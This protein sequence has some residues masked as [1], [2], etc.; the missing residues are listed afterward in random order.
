[1]D[2]SVDRDE[3]TAAQRS[4]S[5]STACAGTT[6]DLRRAQTKRILQLPFVLPFEKRVRLFRR[7][8]L[9]KVL[10]CLTI[11]GTPCSHH[12]RYSVITQYLVAL[13]GYSKPFSPPSNSSRVL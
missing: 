9:R 3:A 8:I 2:D 11:L 12:L 5:R 13:P 7:V 10:R 6:I 1:M 4:A